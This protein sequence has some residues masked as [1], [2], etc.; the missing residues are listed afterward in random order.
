MKRIV[1]CAD[2]TWNRPEEDLRKDFPTNVLRLARAVKPVAGDVEQVVFYDWGIGS[3]HDKAKGGAFGNGINKNIQDCYRFIV[4]NYRSGD[5]LYFFGF[6]RGAYTVR[7]LSGFIFNCGIL[8]RENARLIQKAF[9][10]YK[11]RKTHP[12]DATSTAFRDDYAVAAETKIRFVGAWD[13]VGALGIPFRM[14]GF[15]ND[16]HLF[17]DNKLGPNIQHAR[18]ALAIDEVRDDFDPTIWKTRHS[19]DLKQVWFAGVHA[20]VGGGYGPDPRG[21]T[22]GM[23]LSDIPLNWMKQE[24][25]S[26]GLRFESHL[27]ESL[28]PSPLA[29]Q[30]NEYKGFYKTLGKRV[31]EIPANTYIHKSVKERYLL[32][33]SYRPG[34][35]KDH[36]AAHG[37]SRLTA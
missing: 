22:K 16:K 2:G 28:R 34:P 1:I 23:L 20:D 8:K 12:E 15:L 21:G 37:W 3:Y 13:T 27:K 26:F 5:H 29:Q 25:E 32:R 33:G 36:L 18:H 10:H 4:Q 6:S 24:A 7:S 11:N 14:F 19:V 9:D 31:R 35:L 30:H 17:H